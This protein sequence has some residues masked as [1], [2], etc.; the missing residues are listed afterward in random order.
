MEVTFWVRKVPGESVSVIRCMGCGVTRGG[1]GR[2]G[3]S[4]RGVRG[5]TEG[6]LLEFAASFV[7]TV[8]SGHLEESALGTQVVWLDLGHEVGV[9]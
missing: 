5:R 2:E 1:E 7:G 3:L 4:R 9:T 6:W 8:G